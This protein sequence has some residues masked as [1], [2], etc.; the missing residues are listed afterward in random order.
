MTF[1]TRSTRFNSA[2]SK[3]VELDYEDELIKVQLIKIKLDDYRELH[4][5]DERD[6]KIYNDIRDFIEKNP[7]AELSQIIEKFGKYL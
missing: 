6:K 2:K 5:I 4:L 1:T 3:K 7:D